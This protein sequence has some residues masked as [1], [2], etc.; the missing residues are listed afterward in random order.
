[1]IKFS[2]TLL[3]DQPQI[4]EWMRADSYHRDATDQGMPGWWVTGSDCLL[5]ACIE[6][7]SGPVIYFR[8]DNTENDLIRMHV[9]F[10][11]QNQV[12]KSR[13]ARGIARAMP[14]LKKV[15]QE[16]GAKGFVFESLSP[17]L[18]RFMGVLGFVPMPGKE[19]VDDYVLR[20][21]EK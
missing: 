5:A 14:A 20:F 10:G 17:G 18:I 9:Q 13:V 12:S 8:L 19:N 11:P 1:M 3:D 2:E 4:L 16:K 6:D 21:E 15:A 7:A